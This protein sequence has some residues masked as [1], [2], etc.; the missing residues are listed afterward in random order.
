MVHAAMGLPVHC[1]HTMGLA[2]QTGQPYCSRATMRLLFGNFELEGR[3][4]KDGER[5]L[6][7]KHSR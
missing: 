5:I 6:S 4:R 1:M 3:R 7:A 2:C